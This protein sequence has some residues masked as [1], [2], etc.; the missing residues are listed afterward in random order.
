MDF[1]KHKVKKGESLSVIAKKYGI[2]ARDWKKLYDHPKN[3]AF[4]KLRPDP[5]LIEP[6]DEIF[7]P[8]VSGKDID[9]EM[10]ALQS[11]LD[12]LRSMPPSIKSLV[13]EAKRMGKEAQRITKN[14]AVIQADIKKLRGMA[15]VHKS[16]VKTM[17]AM[18]TRVDRDAKASPA[19]SPKSFAQFQKRQAALASLINTL[20]TI[21]EADK[22]LRKD[23]NKAMFAV[24][25]LG[26]DMAKI[27]KLTND[28]TKAHADAIKEIEAQMKKLQSERKQTI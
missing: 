27:E 17:D 8:K 2:P 13:M 4:R 18:S 12:Q 15:A 19:D 28:W 5:S 1:I 14:G 25:A 3:A 22:H 26:K 21:D 20:K 9:D 11:M 6:K 23:P 7:V 24:G 16:E 10:K